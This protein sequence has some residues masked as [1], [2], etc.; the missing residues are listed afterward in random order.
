MRRLIVLIVCVAVRV[1]LWA[2]LPLGST[3]ATP[4][5]SKRDELNGKIDRR[6]P[7]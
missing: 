4:S 3:A 6:F 1:A 5:Q 7:I 2:A